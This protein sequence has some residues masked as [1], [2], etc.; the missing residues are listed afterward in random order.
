M[1][2]PWAAFLQDELDVRCAGTVAREVAKRPGEPPE[3][4]GR[5]CPGLP[6]LGGGVKTLRLL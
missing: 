1:H 4:F 3:D 6:F 2:S 5:L